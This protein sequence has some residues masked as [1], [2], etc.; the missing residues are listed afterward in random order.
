MKI[1]ILSLCFIPQ[2]SL[3]PQPQLL[4]TLE[5]FYQQQIESELSELNTKQKM[6]WLKYIPTIGVTYTLEGK[7]RPAISWSSTLLYTSQKDKA[8]IIAKKQAIYQKNHLTLEK[9][10]LLLQQLIRQHHF[11][12]QDISFLQDLLKYDLQ[13]F[14]IKKDQAE[15][16]EIPP[17]ELLKATQALRKKEY[18][19][20]QKQRDLL[21]LESQILQ[22]A[23]YFLSLDQFHQQEKIENKS[24]DRKQ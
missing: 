8:Q 19:I 23:K 16:I 15:K 5:S 7:P 12:K 6:K 17:S 21:Q 1:I 2:D 18:N 13:L 4:A 10:K 3:P 14:D 9:E 11:L 24:N 22:V 20:F